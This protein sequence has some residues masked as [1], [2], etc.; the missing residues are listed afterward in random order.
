[1]LVVGCRSPCVVCLFALFVGSLRVACSLLFVDMLVCCF[2]CVVCWFVACC[3]CGLGDGCALCVVYRVLLGCVLSVCG[4]R[5]ARCLFRFVCLF[6]LC[7]LF[8]N[9]LCVL[10]V[11]C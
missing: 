8:A 4:L 1:M 5:I 10:V 7:V 11:R 9:W 6:V 3:F 2:L